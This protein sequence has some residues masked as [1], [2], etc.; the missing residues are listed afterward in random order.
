MTFCH[1]QPVSPAPDKCKSKYS[2]SQHVK[3]NE[4]LAGH[5]GLPNDL[6]LGPPLCVKKGSLASQG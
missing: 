4:I 6:I 5:C 2:E 3:Q 1:W